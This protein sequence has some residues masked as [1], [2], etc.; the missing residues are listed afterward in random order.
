MRNDISAKLYD[1]IAQVCNDVALCVLIVFLIKHLI[2]ITWHA[3]QMK[4][5]RRRNS[6]IGGRE[7]YWKR[8]IKK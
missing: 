4:R 5:Y 3:V 8:P 2:M 1:S 7:F 6:N